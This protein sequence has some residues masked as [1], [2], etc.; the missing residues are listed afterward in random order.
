MC[1]SGQERQREKHIEKH[2]EK[3][4]VEKHIEKHIEK[5]LNVGS[6][7]WWPPTLVAAA[8]EHSFERLLTNY[9]NRCGRPADN[10]SENITTTYVEHGAHIYM[11]MR[12]CR[13][14]SGSVPGPRTGPSE[15]RTGPELAGGVV[16]HNYNASS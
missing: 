4:H 12:M 8:I 3:K 14:Q 15:A 11:S 6:G 2:I 9:L 1:E 10:A 7:R 5:E 16:A 13:R